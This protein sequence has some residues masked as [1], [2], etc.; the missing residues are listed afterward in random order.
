MKDAT[1]DNE[2]SLS[3]VSSD[4]SI[5]ESQTIKG[6]KAYKVS[7]AGTV[8]FEFD[9]VRDAEDP[10]KSWYTYRVKVLDFFKS[11]QEKGRAGAVEGV[12]FY[13]GYSLIGNYTLSGLECANDNVYKGSTEMVADWSIVLIYSSVEIS[14]K[15]IYMYDG[16][17]VYWHELSEINVTGFEFPIDPEIRI[18]LASHE[19]DPGL[20]DANPEGHMLVPEGI[21][22]HQQQM[23]P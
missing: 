3:F 7:E 5:S 16:F 12:A 2:V 23:Q 20:A 15:K 10:N 13:D 14:P 22:V 6:K 4:G 11:I 9:G 21:Q 17:K 1:T 18:T 19:G 8:D